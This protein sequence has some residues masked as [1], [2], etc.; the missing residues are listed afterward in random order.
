[1]S[2]IETIDGA[3]KNLRHELSEKASES[4]RNSV[5]SVLAS[6]NGRKPEIIGTCLLIE[7]D[8]RRYVVTAAHILDNLDTHSI[9]ISGA[10]GTQPVQIVGVV[11]MTKPPSDGRKFDKIDLAFWEIDENTAQNLGDVEFINST[12]FS[13]NQASLKYRL[14]LAMGFPVSR[15]KKSVDNPNKAIR[16]SLS[17]YTAELLEDQGLNSGLGVTGEQHLF[18]KFQDQSEA[19]NGEVRNTFQPRGLSGGSLIDLGNFAA[20][21]K[22]DASLTQ[23]AFLA[24]MIIE[25]NSDYQVLV[26]IRVQVILE[27][28]RS[29]RTN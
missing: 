22:Y 12:R 13:H 11:N 23:N 19:F 6:E 14:Y 21:T 27:S 7:V 3:V 25:R 2:I 15:N 1:M 20:P 18:L 9:Y 10:I 26:A 24:G 17:K 5:R 28:I 8:G 16:P 4:F 29:Q